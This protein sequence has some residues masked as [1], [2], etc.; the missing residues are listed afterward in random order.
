MSFMRQRVAGRAGGGVIAVL[1][2][3][4][5]VVQA[6]AGSLAC[7][8]AMSAGIGDDGFVICTQSGTSTVE[9]GPDGAPPDPEPERPPPCA[10][11]CRPGC[12]IPAAAAP[13]GSIATAGPRP[14][15][16][17]GPAVFGDGGASILVPE[18]RGPPP[19]SG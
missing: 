17:A 11:S 3:F 14:A 13:D 15:E 6:F 9:A 12:Q 18:A 19:L 7:G 2:A 4:L 5:L 10:A 16:D 8:A 1:A